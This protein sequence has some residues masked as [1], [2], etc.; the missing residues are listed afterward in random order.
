MTLI[1]ANRA[2]TKESSDYMQSL[3][4][5]INTSNADMKLKFVSATPSISRVIKL[6]DSK[7]PTAY[8]IPVPIGPTWVE[9]GT[10]LSG[11]SK[12][13]PELASAPI[14]PPDAK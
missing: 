11:H 6:E 4:E 7:F 8:S 9:V 13:M 2:T 10:L 14:P 5:T 3:I 1:L 12:E